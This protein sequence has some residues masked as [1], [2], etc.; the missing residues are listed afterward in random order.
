MRLFIALNLP[1]AVRSAIHRSTAPLRAAGLPVRWVA[2]DSIHVTLKFLGWVRPER[3]VEVRRT[4]AEAAAKTRPFELRL[5]GLGAFPTR[6]R[7]RV[8][9]MGVE[10]TPPLRCLKHDLEWLFTPLG[11]EREIRAFQP[12]LTLGRATREAR[13]GD[14]RE[15]EPLLQQVEFGSEV[16]VDRVDL[17]RS[18]LT[19]AAA[20]Y[21][22]IASEPLG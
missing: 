5:G 1:K 16:A 13:A 9:W 20:A 22:R 11:F 10:A 2:A 3:V 12:H 15:L 7:P 14:F 19:G 6:R 18:E 17:M 8:I 21:E 4:M